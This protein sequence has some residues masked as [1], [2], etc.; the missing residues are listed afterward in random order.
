MDVPSAKGRSQS[1]RLQVQTCLQQNTIQSPLKQFE[2]PTGARVDAVSRSTLP[3]NGHINNGKAE[4]LPL[5]L[6]GYN[7]NLANTLYAFIDI[8][9]FLAQLFG[10][11]NHIFMIDTKVL[12]YLAHYLAHNTFHSECRKYPSLA[13]FCLAYILRLSAKSLLIIISV[14][15]CMLMI[16]MFTFHFHNHMHKNLFRL[17]VLSY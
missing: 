11:S 12:S 13:L 6:Q 7:N 14:I 9:A 8:S 5:L 10:G 3:K 1:A 2:F 4:Y 17:Q 16:Y 15:T